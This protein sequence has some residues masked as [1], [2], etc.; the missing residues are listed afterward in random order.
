M[1]HPV[2]MPHVIGVWREHRP[3][4]LWPP[5]SLQPLIEAGMQDVLSVLDQVSRQLSEAGIRHVAI[6]GLA[7]GVYGWPRASREV[8]LLVGAEAF[9]KLPSGELEPRR[10]LPERV[11]G[12][13][14]NYLYID[15]AGRFLDRAFETPV[16]VNGIPF[17]P[18][19]ILVCTKLLRLTMRDQADIVDVLKG[20]VVDRKRIRAFLGA[21]LP[22]LVS[23]Y[24]ALASQADAEIERAMRK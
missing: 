4:P 20:K 15:E 21:R 18:P 6:G 7:A 13:P 3:A 5:P 17:A 16:F 19:E 1:L 11:E 2:K 10:P 24:D 9:D 8:D 14:V 12:I 23:H 22:L